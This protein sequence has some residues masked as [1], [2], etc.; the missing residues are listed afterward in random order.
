MNPSRFSRKES[1]CFAAYLLLVVPAELYSRRVM[2]VHG[3]TLEGL[4]GMKLTPSQELGV[5]DAA[6]VVISQLAAM[7]ADRETHAVRDAL[8]ALPV[9]IPAIAGSSGPPLTGG[10]AAKLRKWAQHIIWRRQWTLPS[11]TIDYI[12]NHEG[13]RH[14]YLSR[15]IH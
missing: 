8:N 7:P 9:L 4:S 3:D 11:S 12:K 10:E 5:R 15:H 1:F 6:K 2:H 14:T 13:P